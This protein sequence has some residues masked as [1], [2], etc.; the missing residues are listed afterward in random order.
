MIDGIPRR[1]II[2]INSFRH[3]IENRTFCFCFWLFKIHN[4][5]YILVGLLRDKFSDGYSISVFPVSHVLVKGKEVVVTGKPFDSIVFWRKPIFYMPS[6]H[7]AY[8]QFHNFL[9]IDVT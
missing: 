2:G 4:L 6:W 8:L 7:L 5:K 9:Q 3:V 1:Y